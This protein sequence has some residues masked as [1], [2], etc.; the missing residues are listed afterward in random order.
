MAARTQYQLTLSELR[1]VHGRI[2]QHSLKTEDYVLF[3]HFVSNLIGREEMK[4][5]KLAAKIAD[6]RAAKAT[7][8]A[9]A[10]AAAANLDGKT[11]DA[12]YKPIDNTDAEGRS[13]APPQLGAGPSNANDS[14]PNDSPGHD[15]DPSNGGKSKEGKRGKGNPIGN[16]HGRNGASTFSNALHVFHA[17]MA[18]ILGS[19]CS[20]CGEARMTRYRERVHIRVIGQP[21]LGAECHHAEQARCKAC[22]RVISALPERVTE[23]LGKSVTWAPSAAAMLIVLHYFYGMPFKRIE[24]LHKGWGIPLADATQWEISA[25]A[26]TDLA[27]LVSPLIEWAIQN[28]TSFSMDDTGSMI[29]TL[30]RQIANEL[31]AAKALGI[32]EDNV[33]TGINA[34]GFY[35]VTPKG[36]VVL[37]FTGRHHATEILRRLIKHR[38]PGSP[39]VNK[40]TDGASKNFSAEFKDMMEEGVCNTHAFLNF[41]DHQDKFPA[42]YAVVGEAYNKIYENEGTAADRKMSPEEHLAFHQMHSQPWMEKIK[43]LCE[44]LVLSRLIEPRTPLY[45]AVHFFLNQWPRLTKF[46]EVAGMGLDTNLCEQTLI[47]PVR[48]LAASYNYHTQNGAEVGDAGMSLVATSRANDL[49][50]WA[51]ITDCLENRAD[52]A[53]NPEKYFPW[54][55]KER[56]KTKQ[57]PPPT[58]S[59]AIH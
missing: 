59:D 28:M 21:F 18:G 58:P 46:L 34:S 49:E 27:P 6:E 30:K 31:K 20:R 19:I 7:A 1:E 37:Y 50:P 40:L 24:I 54:N 52:L 53:K 47:A 39:K 22:G 42:A 11:I 3:G 8:A 10:A 56:L 48:Y 12:E 36:I 2:D 5:F 44:D 9:E 38:L 55:F 23:G 41:Y 57:D 51:W 45:E 35:I 15:G 33:R 14:S 13:P 4:L 25:E 32:P 17:L 29:L 16:G 26:M 43:A